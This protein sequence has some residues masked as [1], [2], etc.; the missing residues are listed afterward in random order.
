MNKN[1]VL[2]VAGFS[3]EQLFLNEI[4]SN[5]SSLTHRRTPGDARSPS[6]FTFSL[7]AAMMENF[8]AFVVFVIQHGVDPEFNSDAAIP[9]VSDFGPHF[10]ERQ[11]PRRAAEP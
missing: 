6:P 7:L 11:V 8:D 1:I 10:T 5:L 9:A 4:N 3:L 2:D